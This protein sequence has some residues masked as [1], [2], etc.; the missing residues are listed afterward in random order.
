MATS[1]QVRSMDI[2][3]IE[4]STH[5]KIEYSLENNNKLQTK[6][7]LFGINHSFKYSKVAIPT[8]PP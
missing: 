8:K 2:D 5:R 3:W 7:N 1:S 4:K 6:C